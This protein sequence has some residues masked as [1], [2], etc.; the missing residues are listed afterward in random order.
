MTRRA[1]GVFAFVLA[2]CGEGTSPTSGSNGFVSFTHTG[3]GG[4]SF[5]LAARAPNTGEEPDLNSNM[6]LGVSN[7]TIT[8]AGAAKSRGGGYL[9]VVAFG[10]TRATVGSAAI[11]ADCDPENASVC[12]ALIFGVNVDSSGEGGDS[13]LMCSLTSG[14]ISI[15]EITTSRIVGTFSGSGECVSA[16]EVTS[17]FAIA[18]GTF[19]VYRL[20]TTSTGP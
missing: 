4:G 13:D 10:L 17:P 7:D 12:A 3:A 19:N 14:S 5:Y 20:S 2:A 6:T 15:T 11:S 8:F 18:G 16:L 9:D 1:L